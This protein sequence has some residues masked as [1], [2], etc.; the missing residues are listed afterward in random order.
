LAKSMPTDPTDAASLKTCVAVMAEFTQAWDT[1]GTGAKSHA[2][3][4]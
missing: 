1:V 2:E 3:R 4:A